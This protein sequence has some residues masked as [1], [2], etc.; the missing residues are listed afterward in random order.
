MNFPDVPVFIRF[1]LVELI[2]VD[3][4]VEELDVLSKCFGVFSHHFV[5]RIGLG[6]DRP[7]DFLRHLLL[8]FHHALRELVVELLYVLIDEL[9]HVV[10][11]GQSFEDRDDAEQLFVVDIV[12]EALDRKAVIWVQSVRNRRVVNDHCLLQIA[13]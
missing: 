5:I 2:S 9:L 7:V 4:V 10:G 13:T 6:V 12:V 8:G 11:L 3:V 1:G